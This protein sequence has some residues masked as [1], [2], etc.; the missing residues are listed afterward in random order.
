MR[1]WHLVAVTSSSYLGRKQQRRLW[2]LNHLL[3]LPGLESSKYMLRWLLLF[4]LLPQDK[5]VEAFSS[6]QRFCSVELKAF[7]T[8]TKKQSAQ[9]SWCCQQNTNCFEGG[10]SEASPTPPTTFNYSRKFSHSSL[11][12]NCKSVWSKMRVVVMMMR[13]TRR[14]K[15]RPTDLIWKDR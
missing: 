7:L 11:K 5:W 3:D 10:R 14:V 9:W 13:V 12:L 2:Q 15:N 8:T 1:N 4:F 6:T